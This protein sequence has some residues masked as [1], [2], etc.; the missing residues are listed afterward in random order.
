LT[1]DKQKLA[2]HLWFGSENNFTRRYMKY[3][4]I[5]TVLRVKPSRIRMI[6]KKF[7]DNGFQFK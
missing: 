3:S 5:A 7:R 6:V 1:F 2:V 4:E